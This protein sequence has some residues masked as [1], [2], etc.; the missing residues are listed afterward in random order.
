MRWPWGHCDDPPGD[1]PTA[2]SESAQRALRKA[3]RAKEETEAQ[4][5]AIRWLT[6]TLQIHRDENHFAEMFTRAMERK[7]P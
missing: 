2:D 4:W 5:P 3:E 1:L 6:A 7:E